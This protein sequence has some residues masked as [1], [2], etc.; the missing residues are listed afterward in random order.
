M[1]GKIKF[2]K[3]PGLATSGERTSGQLKKIMPDNNYL[4]RSV[5][6]INYKRYAR[7]LPGYFRH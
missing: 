4:S 5:I 2:S 6:V 1:S 3:G 7:F